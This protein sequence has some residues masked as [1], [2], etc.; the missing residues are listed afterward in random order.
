MLPLDKLE[1]WVNSLAEKKELRKKS[2]KLKIEIRDQNEKS[3]N[4]FMYPS[5]S[6]RD[7]KVEGQV[8]ESMFQRAEAQAKL[9]KL[10]MVHYSALKRCF[11]NS[12]KYHVVFEELRKKYELE[13]DVLRYVKFP[14][15]PK[16]L[17]T[18]IDP[19]PK[20]KENP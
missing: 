13:E 12:E 20:Y 14:T 3:R 5:H 1:L 8:V 7:R 10:E 18:P 19:P 9:N 15:V 17:E 4:G 11:E 16:N 2:I 6:E